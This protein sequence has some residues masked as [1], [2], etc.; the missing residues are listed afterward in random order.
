M[1]KMTRKEFLAQ[2]KKLFE[3]AYQI[4]LIKNVDYA[5]ED[6]PFE[7]FRMFGRYGILCRIGDKISRLKTIHKNKGKHAV[8][9][10]TVKDTVLDALNYLVFYLTYDGAE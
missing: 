9:S 2:H 7:N 4:I 10:E 5:S 3:E 8:K 6:D 1:K